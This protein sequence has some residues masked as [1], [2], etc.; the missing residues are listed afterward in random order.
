MVLPFF[1]VEN[2]IYTKCNPKKAVTILTVVAGLCILSG[3]L[4]FFYSD[5]G[6]LGLLVPSVLGI[7]IL[8][9]GTHKLLINTNTKQ[10]QKSFLFG[11][12][13]SNKNAKLYNQLLLEDNF[14]NGVYIGKILYLANDKNLVKKIN[15]CGPFID[16]ANI[17]KHTN[18]VNQ[19]IDKLQN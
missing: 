7:I 14:V 19:I 8:A 12:I 9:G 2:G 1:E 11:L 6:Y 4:L 17:D 5:Q 18:I 10:I 15:V 13:S 16:Q 3:I